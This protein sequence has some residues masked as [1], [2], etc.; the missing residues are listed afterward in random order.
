VWGW[1]DSRDMVWPGLRHWRIPLTPLG[2]EDVTFWLVA[3][4]LET[5]H[6][7]PPAQQ[8]SSGRWQLIV[9]R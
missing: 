5:C 9:V 2:I 7:V 4:C 6:H 3:Q 1:V 8:H